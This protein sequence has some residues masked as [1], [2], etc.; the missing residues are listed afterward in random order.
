MRFPSGDQIGI[1]ANVDVILI[2]VPFS[3]SSTQMLL[4]PPSFGGFLISSRLPSGEICG[5]WPT[6]TFVG[7]PI[8]PTCLPSLSY[9]ASWYSLCHCP[10]QISIPLSETEKRLTLP[11]ALRWPLIIVI[12]SPDSLFVESSVCA[13]RASLRT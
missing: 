9:Q 11:N 12:A 2:V 1:W 3:R 13:T 4:L 6:L 10:C 5:S 8:V 7:V